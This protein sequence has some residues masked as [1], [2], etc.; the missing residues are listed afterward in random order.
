MG[1]GC[2]MI[3]LII[4]IV[5]AVIAFPEITI[6]F[7]LFGLVFF[8]NEW[9]VDVKPEQFSP[10]EFL[11]SPSVLIHNTITDLHIV[12]KIGIFIA[13]PILY[14][15][16]SHF[17]HFGPIYPLQILGVGFMIYCIFM[18]LHYP[19]NLNLDMIW[20]VSLTIIIG[21]LTLGARLLTFKFLDSI[22]GGNPYLREKSFKSSYE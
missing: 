11:Y 9:M 17:I 5:I 15:L 13:I 14:L 2:I 3:E 19:Q 21:F 22:F 6:Y 20:S 18:M 10:F 16:V 12:F 4:G 1:E 8:D 7:I